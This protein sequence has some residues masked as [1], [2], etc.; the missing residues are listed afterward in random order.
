M[1]L[2]GD[3]RLEALI[4]PAMV[5][6]R[7]V[8]EDNPMHIEAMITEAVNVYRSEPD[9]LRALVVLLAAMVRDDKTEREL[10]AW[11]RNPTEYR[12]LRKAG[13]DADT[14]GTMAEKVADMLKGAA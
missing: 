12:R 4:D 2:T 14:A 8:H 1:S 5:I 9:G 6:V 13:V 11:F 3:R 10:L 7:A